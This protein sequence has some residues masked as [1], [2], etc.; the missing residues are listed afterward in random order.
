M[1]HDRNG[2]N[3][4]M[5]DEYFADMMKNATYA[6]F[7]E[8]KAAGL[9]FQVK[10]QVYTNGLIYTKSESNDYSVRWL[11]FS[12]DLSS[13]HS[14]AYLPIAAQKI[15]RRHMEVAVGENDFGIDTPSQH[16]VDK[17]C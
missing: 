12:R 8:L 6:G 16:K 10:F 9:I 14:D 5:P 13:G 2:G 3:Y 7:C 17:G 11:Q 15:T 4:V 1:N